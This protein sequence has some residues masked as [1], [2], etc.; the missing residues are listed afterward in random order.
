MA[1]YEYEIYYHYD[2]P[3]ASNPFAKKKSEQEIKDAFLS[4]KSEF[5]VYL[6]AKLSNISLKDVIDYKT[7]RI[8]TIETT[9]NDEEVYKTVDRCLQNLDLRAKLLTK[10]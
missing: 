9:A 2:G 1:K 7:K 5:P 4:F 3:S 10:L 6:D 8:F